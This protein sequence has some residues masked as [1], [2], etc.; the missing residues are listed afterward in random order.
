MSNQEKEI[1]LRKRL[2]KA[3]LLS[4]VL[5]FSL[6]TLVLSPLFVYTCSDVVYADTVIPELIDIAIDITDV[7]AYGL[8]FAPIAYS[9][10]RFGTRYSA[11]LAVV[12]AAACFVRYTLNLAIT[13]LTY[14]SI[15]SD[16]AILVL[17]PFV[18]DML[19]L[20]GV[21]LTSSLCARKIKRKD[22]N[23]IESQISDSLL[24]KPFS[25]GDSIHISAFTTGALLSLFRVISRLIYDFSYGPPTS[26]S[27]GLWMFVYY[28][29][30]ILVS[31]VIYAII[32]Y[33]FEKYNTPK[34]K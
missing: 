33:L 18:L 30:D 1:I 15:S 28:T 5:L 23:D 9:I 31:V 22:T 2:F 11:N 25:L 12:Y 26:L 24:K 20:G 17:F 32:I 3:L 19:I 16:D 4:T 13:F 6:S 10:F 27:D 7:L 21:L 14:G 8:C 29:S 34:K